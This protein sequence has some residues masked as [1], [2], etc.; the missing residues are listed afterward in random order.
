MV[1]VA[2]NY[3]CKNCYRELSSEDARCFG[4]T[5]GS[6]IKRGRQA[7]VVVLGISGLPVLIMGVLFLNARLCLL[8]AIISAVA[9][10]IYAVSVVRQ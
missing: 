10:M 3:Y 9:V 8:G 2:G 1:N 7:V 5:P 4:C 6:V